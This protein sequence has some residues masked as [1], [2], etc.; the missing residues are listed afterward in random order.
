MNSFELS[1]DFMVASGRLG[2]LKRRIIVHHCPAGFG[3]GGT[4]LLRRAFALGGEKGVEE[5]AACSS[6]PG[7]KWP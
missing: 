3:L 6:V 1:G 4:G 5:S 2:P 7:I